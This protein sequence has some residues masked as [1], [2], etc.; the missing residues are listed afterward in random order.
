MEEYFARCLLTGTNFSP[1]KLSKISSL[2]FDSPSEKGEINKQ[3]KATLDYGS[4][5][6]NRSSHIGL[7]GKDIKLDKLL[8]VL[9]KNKSN[10]K[11]SGVEDISV[12]LVLGY[13]GDM[14][15]WHIEY[16]DLKKLLEL[17]IG[18][19]IDYYKVD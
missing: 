18:L 13:E 3:I 2:K 9:V 14:A 15:A 19:S 6:I 5:I 7:K 17:G 16:E 10:L 11:A 8:K 4:A 12:T 1:A